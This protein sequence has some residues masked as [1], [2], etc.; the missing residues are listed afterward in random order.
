[1]AAA[2]FCHWNR[3]KPCRVLIN[4]KLAGKGHARTH[5][6][7]AEP[8]DLAL[9]PVHA[10]PAKSP[11][12]RN[13]PFQTPQRGTSRGHSMSLRAEL[14]RL[15]LRTV[16]TVKAARKRRDVPVARIRRRLALIEPIVPRPP[17]GTKT[18]TFDIEGINAV[19]TL[20]RGART[21]LGVWALRPARACCI[22]TTGWLPSTHFRPPSKTPAKCIAGSPVV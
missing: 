21:S 13:L 2:R 14:L 18:T 4:P 1:M 3:S 6:V 12:V 19:E 5:G 15:S 9:R 17:A 22:S 10:A 7:R 8:L 11:I 20:V 16:K